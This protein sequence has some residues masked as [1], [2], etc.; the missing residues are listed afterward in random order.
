MKTTRILKVA[1]LCLSLSAALPALADHQWQTCAEKQQQIDNQMQYA[2]ANNNQRQINRLNAQKA[3]IAQ[4]CN[5]N[6]LRQK[7]QQKI[8]KLNNKIDETQRKLTKAQAKGDNDKV[9]EL[10]NKM[11]ENTAKLQQAKQN[12][13]RFE[14]AAKQ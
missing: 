7:Y 11:N 3:D 13:A 14:Q 4:N 9:A 5:N 6:D 2:R 1:L 12:Y 10:Q 8:A